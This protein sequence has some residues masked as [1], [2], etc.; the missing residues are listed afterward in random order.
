[1]P[2]VCTHRHCRSTSAP[3]IPFR[4]SKPRPLS[5]RCVTDSHE[6]NTRP[7]LTNHAIASALH[8][9]RHYDARPMAIPAGFERPPQRSFKPRRRGLSPT[10]TVAFERAMTRWGVSVAGPP[11]RW[12][13]VFD[14]RSS[15]DFEVVLDIGFGAGEALIE[16]AET[17]PYEH[18][19]GV[20]VH[21]PG[22][23]AVLDAVE[24]RAM[25][26][27]RVVVGDVLGFLRRV[28]D[29]WL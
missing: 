13:D 6:A 16:L 21:T 11:L 29:G 18:V 8:V 26:N 24:S 9:S 28:P 20:D 2:S 12:P 17:R 7:S 25:R 5:R 4:P 10:R 27:V 19:I 15:G 23:A 14:H 1:M 3:S 22:I